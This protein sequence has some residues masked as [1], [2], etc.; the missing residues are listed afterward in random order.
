MDEKSAKTELPHS[1]DTSPPNPTASTNPR[2][3]TGRSSKRGGRLGRNQHTRDASTTEAQYSPRNRTNGDHDGLINGN[4]SG[5]GEASSSGKSKT[6]NYNTNKMGWAEL[7]R[8]VTVMMDSISRIQVE[9]AEER[10]PPSAGSN[11]TSIKGTVAGPS[12]P[13]IPEQ[14]EENSNKNGDEPVG[15]V[16]TMEREFKSLTS[17]EMMD[18]LTRSLMAW[19][20]KYGKESEKV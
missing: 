20:N 12:A 7:R 19:Q 16:G 5:G 17:A 13:S 1:P 18:T 11:A 9:L 4:T 6:R 8:R 3:A 10:T 15:M 2:K 14:S